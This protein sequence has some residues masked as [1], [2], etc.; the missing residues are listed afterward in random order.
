M[1]LLMSA[2]LFYGEWRVVTSVYSP[3]GT[4]TVTV[5]A[6]DAG[7]LWAPITFDIIVNM[8]PRR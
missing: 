8:T 5:S 6:M 3:I 1:I 7:G 2:C 4:T